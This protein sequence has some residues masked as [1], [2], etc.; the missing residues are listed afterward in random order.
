MTDGRMV[1]ATLAGTLS[2]SVPAGRAERVDDVERRA[3]FRQRRRQPLKE[4][5]A[6]L[7]RGDATGRSV[8]EPHTE[9]GFEPANC[10]AE[11]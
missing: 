1:R 3:D 8:E 9:G 10:F 7:R 4:A 2:R 6:D 5:G 11:I